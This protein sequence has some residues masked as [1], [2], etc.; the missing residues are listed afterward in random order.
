MARKKGKKL[1]ESDVEYKNLQEKI[2]DLR[3][4]VL[5]EFDM[6]ELIEDSIKDIFSCD[7]NCATCSDMDRGKCMQSF[8]KGNLY[9]LRKIAQQEQI[10]EG[11][12]SKIDE[13]TKAL[14]EMNRKTRKMFKDITSNDDK[15][16][17]REEEVKTR[18]KENHGYNLYC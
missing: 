10:L 6:M 2:F 13:G 9:W 14:V 5:E 12:V 3:D 1:E 11:I 7:L 15:Y 17:K 4:S 16:K 8:K 18:L